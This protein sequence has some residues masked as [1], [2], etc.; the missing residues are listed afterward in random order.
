LVADH[1]AGAALAFQAMAHR[2]A[3]RFALDGELK[4]SATAC[5]AAGGHGR[6]SAASLAVK[7]RPPSRRSAATTAHALVLGTLWRRAEFGLGSAAMNDNPSHQ[8]APLQ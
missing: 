3:R 1:R 2:N 6:P 4:L 7:F 8:S 5:G